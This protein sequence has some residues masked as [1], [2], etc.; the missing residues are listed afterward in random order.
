[1]G[2]VE[3]R[4]EIEIECID[5]LSTLQYIKY[6]TDKKQVVP[7]LYLI[8][9]LLRSCNAYSHFLV[10]NNIQLTKGGTDTVLD[11]LYIAEENF[12]DRK[13]D[14]ETDE[15]VAWTMQEVLEEVCQYL[16]L[17]AVADGD[18]VYFLDYDAIKHGINTYYKYSVDED[19][20]PSLETISFSKTIKAE[21]YSE[22]GATLSLDNV[23][24]KV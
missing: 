11:K 20:A 4:E 14:K 7:F 16:G 6:S 12:F 3:E 17:T 24:N 8:R 1:M 10:S 22:S 21:D 19:S 18:K 2:F 13:E 5:A 9:K 23:Y 15:D